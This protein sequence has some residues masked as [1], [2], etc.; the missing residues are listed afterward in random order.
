MKASRI[1]RLAGAALCALLVAM[2][3]VP[4]APA[5]AEITSATLS[6]HIVTDTLSEPAGTTVNLFNYTTGKAGANGSDTLGTTGPATPRQNYETWLS[7]DN[8]IN[9]GRLLTFGDGMR[10][11]GYWNQGLTA[12]YGELAGERPGMQGIVERDLVD[13]YPVVRGSASA[14]RADGVFG[15]YDANA[16]D[17]STAQ[18]TTGSGSEMVYFNAGPRY[19]NAL[20]GKG[21]VGNAFF[22]PVLGWN[23]DRAVQAQAAA[24]V[25]DDGTL[26]GGSYPFDRFSQWPA[27]GLGSQPAFDGEEGGVDWAQGYA[28]TEGQR[29]LS[30]LF[31]PDQPNQGKTTYE[32]VRGL[33]Q[34]DDDGYYYYN[35]RENFAEYDEASNRFVLYD[36]PAGV[37]TDGEDSIGNFFPFNSAEEMFELDEEG[38]LKSTVHANNSDGVKVDHHL[39]MTIETDFRQPAGGRVGQRD[40]TFEFVGD[41]DIWV[42]VDDVLVLDMGGVHSEIYGTINF[43]TGAISVGTA[44]NSNGDIFDEDGNYITAPRVTSTLREQYAQAGMAGKLQWNG[45]TFASSTSHTIKVFY[46]ERGNYD[47]S[48]AVRFNLQSALY[49]QLAKV[50]QNGNPLGGAEFELY[51]VD[52]ASIP[53]GT[54]KE[55]AMDVTLG[56]VR[57][58]QYLTSLVTDD[59]GHAKFVGTHVSSYTGEPEPFNFADRY[60][61]GSDGAPPEGLLYLLRETKAPAGYKVV[62]QDLLLSF[63]PD[64]TMLCVNNRWETGSHASFNSYVYGNP[65]SLYYGA[66]G[67]DGGL[68]TKISEDSHV[69]AQNQKDG[70]V[71]AVPMMLNTTGGE[72]RWYPLYGDNLT[73]F[74][75]V[76]Y[77]T[78]DHETECGQ[79]C[80]MA[81]RAALAQ[82]AYHADSSHRANGWFLTWSDKTHRLEGILE[83]LPGQADR[84]LNVNPNGDMRMFYAIVEPKA[85]AAVLGVSEG[86]VH[87]MTSEEAYN[88]L[89]EVAKQ[90]M[91]NTS[92]AS[93]TPEQLAQLDPIIEQ[94]DPF[95]ESYTE[96]GFSAVDA[97]EL[98]RNFRS[99]IY[100]PN[101]VR[102]LRVMKIDQNGDPL[103]GVEFS[104]YGSEA[105]AQ[106]YTNA[107]ATGRTATISSATIGGGNAG[108]NEN[109][110]ETEGVLVFEPR[111]AIPAGHE[112]NGYAAMPWASVSAGQPDVTYYLREVSAPGNI[113]V[114]DAIIPVKAGRYSIYADAG[115][116]GDGVTVM[117][118]VG[119]LTQTM[120]KYTQGDVDITLRDVVAYAQSKPSEDASV[121]QE[122]WSD[123]YLQDTDGV[124]TP[125]SEPEEAALRAL[126]GEDS[127]AVRRSMN[128]RYGTN[129]MIDYGLTDDDGGQYIYPYFVSDEGYVR[130]RVEQRKPERI[131][132]EPRAL[133]AV[134]AEDGADGADA[135]DGT[136]AV[137][138]TGGAG[139]TTRVLDANYEDLGNTNITGLFSLIN[140]VVVMNYNPDAAPEGDVSITKEVA[141]DDLSAETYTRGYDFKFEFFDAEGE[142]L[143]ESEQL[144]FYGDRMG[145]LPSGATMPLSHDDGIVVQGL[146][147][148][149]TYQVTE[150]DADKYGLHVLP[151]GGAQEGEI[152]KSSIRTG[153]YV[154]DNI[155]PAHFL[156]TSALPVEPEPP[157]E[158]EEPEEPGEPDGPDG[159]DD[160]DEPFGPEDPEDPKDPDNPLDPVS[161]IDPVEPDDPNQ[162]GRPNVPSDSV[163]PPAGPVLPSRD[164]LPQP[165]RTL[166][167]TTRT[168]GGLQITGDQAG[169][170]ALLLGIA[171][172]C[173][174][175]YLL[176]ASRR[177]RA[178]EGASDVDLS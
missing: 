20:F 21:T 171:S 177:A 143:E 94:I 160:P 38:D 141:G 151:E 147:A 70:I 95:S 12:T 102:S 137:G 152:V 62:P 99:V 1:S 63:N 106:S 69:P 146:P 49:Q 107:L 168:L 31:D 91:G 83:T 166:L 116:A 159:P 15:G 24:L 56:E 4:T 57:A 140:T 104:I 89:G 76:T 131:N 173:M 122:G 53:A 163:E 40:M 123:I 92:G 108:E 86:D 16:A 34:I 164:P 124:V 48:L 6:S 136:G 111:L 32:D 128:L 27:D 43:A 167:R 28:L 119:K 138:G 178:Q 67:E 121:G 22:D 30:Y 142:P 2:P 60:S 169:G 97:S 74:N 23:V 68:V 110:R 127:T 135:G 109:N 149:A 77:E 51:E 61:P 29:S 8:N 175:V 125:E 100:V 148:G 114:N 25:G 47:S 176:R 157:V 115:T 120:V 117:A 35:M 133:S 145:S 58:G 80:E 96:R 93:V 10:H 158:P 84:Y 66:I 139:G 72:S 85:L 126:S 156:N 71:L 26:N 19:Y 170:A 174:G 17:Y 162:P 79:A 129:A 155:A 113:E 55:N 101:E 50:D 98:V 132:G 172:A 150:V 3:L 59:A 88:A 75:A 45:D 5:E 37:R 165:T 33:F 161:P 18:R 144:H 64:T 14:G 154:N 81:L 36:A 46:L 11:L 42:F 153:H 103:N 118:G 39:G 130:A 90:A 105:D 52:P 7:G 87:S 9:K 112:G 73:G 78:G 134:D 54:T 41:D 82:M 65:A 13:G 44:Y